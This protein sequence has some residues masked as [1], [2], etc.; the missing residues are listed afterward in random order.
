MFIITKMKNNFFKPFFIIAVIVFLIFPRPIS[1]DL[2]GIMDAAEIALDGIEEAAAP[3]A[4]QMIKQ[5]QDFV[6][7]LFVLYFSTFIFKFGIAATATIQIFSGVSS[8]FSIT[9]NPFLGFAN[10]FIMGIANSLLVLFFVAI[11]LATILKIETLQAKKTLPK[12]ILVALL[13]N[14]SHVFAG[15]IVD[16]GN[17]LFNTFCL[18]ASLFPDTV[19]TTLGLSGMTSFFLLVAQIIV[20]A[21]AFM[22]PFV[23]AAAQFA[24]VTMLTAAILPLTVW[25]YS[26]LFA[27][28]I[29]SAIF[30]TYGFLFIARLFVLQILTVLSPLAFVSIALPQTQKYFNSWLKWFLEWVFLGIVLGFFLSIGWS[31]L[32]PFTSIAFL[33]FGVFILSTGMW[34]LGS[35]GALIYYVAIFFYLVICL[36]ISK[37][38]MP[39]GANFLIDQT[40]ALGGMIWNQG[41]KPMASAIRRQ[42]I[43]AAAQYE[44][45]EKHGG[46]HRGLSR[47]VGGTGATLTRW[48]TQTTKGVTP[49]QM[50]EEE[51]EK[52]AKR[53][54]ERY[55]NDV[56]RALKALA[57]AGKLRTV[58]AIEKK[59]IAS[60]LGDRA[61]KVG[62]DNLK[63][64]SGAEAEEMKQ[65]SN[66][67]AQHAPQKGLDVLKSNLDIIADENKF[68]N[69][70]SLVS[71]TLG[72]DTTKETAEARKEAAEKIF[73][74]ITPQ[75]VKTK[76]SEGNVKWFQNLVETVNSIEDDKAKRK[77]LQQN[78][79]TVKKINEIRKSLGAKVIPSFRPR[80]SK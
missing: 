72:V 19:L 35:A 36:W 26:Q 66:L 78:T 15:M 34:W 28:G 41:I 55:G 10:R 63:F 68:T 54:Q 5:I 40:K 76:L 48:Y 12:L 71:K 4:H 1:A 50:L 14:F 61:A 44:L 75:D 2:A 51:I 17:I 58:G 80:K 8:Y 38:T 77:V 52:K 24:L 64:T 79:A 3:I 43:R 6:M 20:A 9:Q 46:K 11:G 53:F 74:K 60:Y 27:F 62:L 29:I 49:G 21:G 13:V 47:I 39:T 69:F 42:S 37:Q 31:I 59:A 33:V 16:I 18:P 67:I 56:S 23:G 57:V 73:L 22:I 70:Q 30:G 65:M 7:G 32:I 45:E 25:V